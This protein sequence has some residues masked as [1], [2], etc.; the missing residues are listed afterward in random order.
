MDGRDR[1]GAYYGGAFAE[2]LERGDVGIDRL[3]VQTQPPAGHR[4]CDGSGRYLSVLV[5]LKLR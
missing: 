2:T 1:S 5:G 4:C 3:R